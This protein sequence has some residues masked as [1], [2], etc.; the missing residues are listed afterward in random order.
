[1][2]AA[3]KSRGDQLQRLKHILS[4]SN[5]GT[6]EWNI[7]TGETVFNERWAEIIGY[8]LSELT[9]VSIETWIRNT[10]PDDL[11]VSNKILNALFIG[12]TDSYVC[13]ARM[14]H[15]KGHWVWV[16]DQ[17]KIIS[18]TPDGKPEWMTGSHLDISELK[19]TE[20]RLRISEQAFRESFH[21]AAV[22]MATLDTKGQ[23]KEVNKTLCD[24]LGYDA[25]EFTQLTFQDL[26]HPDDLN[27]DLSL[28]QQVLKSEIP[29][30]HMEKRYYHKS[31]RIVHA[32]LAVSLVRDDLGEPLHF[33]SQIIDISQRVNAERERMALLE[34]TK[35]NNERLRN[36][37]HV[38]THDLRSHSGN[39]EGLLEL[40]LTERN[41]LQDDKVFNLL[42]SASENLSRNIQN[43]A[44]VV[45]TNSA[46]ADNLEATRLKPVIKSCVENA[47]AMARES[48]IVISMDIPNDLKAL[49][50]PAYL[51]SIVHN[52]ITNAIRYSS[53]QRKS[54][55]R[56]SAEVRKNFVVLSV[57]DN[58]LGIDLTQH[59][60]QLF[61]LHNTFH[62]HPDSRGIGLFITRNQVEAMGGLI[63]VESQVNVGTTFSVFLRKSE[64]G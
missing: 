18:R 42:R 36:F 32:I 35:D 17:G 49:V 28:V 9:P 26:T 59:K 55:V 12:E 13:E 38:V 10:H 30:Y 19:Q 47:A 45:N 52:L 7:Q 50:L 40:L 56:I 43:L 63:E 37:A 48:E 33:I 6:W 31:G 11:E 4:G 24:I 58:G 53:P 23:W 25:N 34:I 39:I 8:D 21:N 14:K 27:K 54:V 29:F 44:E 3:E 46:L 20:L 64:E 41:E 57:E 5:I 60:S 16:L 1:M 51:E 22:G 15:K 62:D 2:H 61:K